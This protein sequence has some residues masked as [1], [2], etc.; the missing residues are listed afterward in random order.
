MEFMPANEW[1]EV[2]LKKMFSRYIYRRLGGMA[3]QLSS[4]K[5][6]FN[7]VWEDSPAPVGPAD[8]ESEFK[9]IALAGLFNFWEAFNDFFAM[10]DESQPFMVPQVPYN[11]TETEFAIGRNKHVI[12]GT[13]DAIYMTVLGPSIVKW[14]Y[15][16]PY[17]HY[18]DVEYEALLQDYAFTK[19][20]KKKAT[21]LVLFYVYDGSSISY[22]RPASFN[23]LKYYNHLLDALGH[24]HDHHRWHPR[25]GLHCRRCPFQEHCMEVHGL[26]VVNVIGQK[27]QKKKLN[28]LK[29]KS[30]GLSELRK[31]LDI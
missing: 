6:Y 13:I 21:D 30:T 29:R 9:R 17:S 19:K 3:Q 4:M 1:I 14:V 16:K 15:Y 10:S 26:D 27:R 11:Y 25:Y 28:P 7:K 24:Y 22:G 18:I 31:V 23:V 8:L 12:K 20:T 2:V 5:R